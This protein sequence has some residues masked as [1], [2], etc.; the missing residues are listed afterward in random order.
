MDIIT[1]TLIV[2]MTGLLLLSPSQAN[3]NHPTYVLMPQTHGLVEW[4]VAQVG[5]RAPGC[6]GLRDGVCWESLD[7]WSLE[8]G[9]SSTNP[10]AVRFPYAES[11][12]TQLTGLHVR[13]D[14]FDPQPDTGVL[15]ARVILHSGAIADQ[16]AMGRWSLRQDS[17]RLPLANVIAWRIRNVPTAS[18]V[19]RLKS[20]RD[21]TR[22]K[23]IP[24]PS[25][26]QLFIRHV[27]P[28]EISGLHPAPALH[29]TA[30]HFDAIYDLFDGDIAARPLPVYRRRDWFHRCR[31]IWTL[32]P[33]P[34]TEAL[35]LNASPTTVSCMMA[36][37]FPS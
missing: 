8:V 6:A 17:E 9:T 28:T 3:G 31:Q 15:K 34:R 24:L 4:H 18:G 29:D 10:G 33:P 13:R 20:L 30:E 14:L 12:L 26:G 19:L 27:R 7:G 1:T 5:Y 37:G 2:R 36:T 23:T 22:V 21:P 32:R 16:C 35:H 25:D 11:N